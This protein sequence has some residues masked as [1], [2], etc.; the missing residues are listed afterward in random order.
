MASPT[1]ND[2]MLRL[3]GSGQMLESP[4]EAPPKQ[5]QS[6]IRHSSELDALFEQEKK[7]KTV[8]R[9]VMLTH[10]ERHRHVAN[11]SPIDPAL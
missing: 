1:R 2:Q 10:L 9:V 7:S 5:H 3:N 4:S 8:K 11:V 6:C